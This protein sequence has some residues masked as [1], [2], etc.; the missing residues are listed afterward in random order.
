MGRSRDPD[1]ML[2]DKRNYLF[3]YYTRFLE[4]YRPRYFVFENVLGLLSAKDEQGYRY[5]D[6]MTEAFDK[7]G[8]KIDLQILNAT[9]YGILQNRKRIIIVGKRT[10]EAEFLFAWPDHTPSESH[11]GDVFSDLPFLHAGE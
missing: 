7:A 4:R 8:Y 10:E 1:N 2:H 11:V 5:L 6:M 9:D 3:S